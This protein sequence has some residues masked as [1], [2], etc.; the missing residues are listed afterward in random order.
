MD[1]QELKT[2]QKIAVVQTMRQEM[3]ISFLIMLLMAFIWVLFLSGGLMGIVGTVNYILMVFCVPMVATYIIRHIII[4]V[5]NKGDFTIF[6][7]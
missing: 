1:F 2:S 5:R 6:F 7:D 4:L 3:N